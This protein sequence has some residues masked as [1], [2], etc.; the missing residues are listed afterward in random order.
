MLDLNKA[1]VGYKSIRKGFEAFLL[2]GEALEEI[3]NLQN[4][5]VEAEVSAKRAKDELKKANASLKD[6]KEKL[7]TVVARNA[8]VSLEAGKIMKDT[9]IDVEMII[10]EANNK[11]TTIVGEARIWIEKA[12]KETVKKVDEAKKTLD[13]LNKDRETLMHQVEALK[14]EFAKLK[15]RLG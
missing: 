1:V 15:R 6:A 11:A 12:K 2:V 8:V 13:R 9:K 5:K 4:Y 7:D 3:N 14:E 10:G